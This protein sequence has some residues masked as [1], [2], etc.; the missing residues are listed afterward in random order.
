MDNQHFTTALLVGQTPKEAFDAINNVRSWWTENMEGHSQKLHDEFEVRYGDVHYSKQK[1][2]EVIP[3]TKVVWLVTDSLLNFIKDKSEWT[4]NKISFEISRQ[5]D[6]TLIRF[7]QWGLVPQI[8]CFGDCSNAWR[9]YINHSL[10]SLIT[11]GKGKPHPKEG[12]TP[13]NEQKDLQSIS[14][15]PRS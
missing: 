8:E 1:L 15:K 5:D 11:T 13:I 3:D 7:T 4:G 14:K 12:K 6:K 2:I 9:N 10:Y